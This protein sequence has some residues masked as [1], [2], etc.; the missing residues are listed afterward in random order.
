MPTYKRPTRKNPLRFN[1]IRGNK[2]KRKIALKLRSA[3]ILA[4]VLILAI[5]FM[6]INSLAPGGVIEWAQN[7]F[8]FAR[9]DDGWGE[10]SLGD[11]ARI[12]QTSNNNSMVLTDTALIGFNSAGNLLFNRLHG[13]TNPEMITNST[14]TLIFDR[15]G[16]GVRVHNLRSEL[17]F[18]RMDNA[19]ITG[20][21]SAN[22]TVA[23]ATRSTQRSVMSEIHIYNHN[24]RDVNVI[25]TYDYILTDIAISDNGRMVYGLFL[26]AHEGEIVSIV[27][28]FNVRNGQ[29]AERI[30]F[31]GIFLFNINIMGNRIAALGED[32]VVSLRRNLSYLRSYEFGGGQMT[33]FDIGDSAIAVVLEDSEQSLIKVISRNARLVTEHEIYGEVLRV[34]RVSG[35]V[36]ALRHQEILRIRDSGRTESGAAPADTI[37]VGMARR[38]VLALSGNRLRVVEVER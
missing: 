26:S 21:L 10:T 16:R 7:T 28:S 17:H 15:D 11:S 3:V 24:W 18:D 38:Q 13:F 9:T 29:M 14:R 2:S 35:A 33:K 20:D 23:L 37:D 8:I 36:I 30:D 12:L 1:I 19:I 22:G 34:T 25:N 32:R 4:G 31:N 5:I 6:F 27:K